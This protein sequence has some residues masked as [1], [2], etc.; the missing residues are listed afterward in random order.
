MFITMLYDWLIPNIISITYY[1]TYI[2]F[3]LFARHQVADIS[4]LFYL[5]IFLLI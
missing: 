3:L 4:F 2:E 5:F 1:L